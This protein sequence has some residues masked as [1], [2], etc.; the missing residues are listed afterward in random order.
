MPGGENL[1]ELRIVHV[2]AESAIDRFQVRAIS[3]GDKLDAAFDPAT[4]IVHE[5]EGGLA[6][7]RGASFRAGP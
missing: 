5:S 7:R 1:N 2:T 6:R 3:V 4:Q